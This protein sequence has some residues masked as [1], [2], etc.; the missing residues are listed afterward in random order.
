MKQSRLKRVANNVSPWMHEQVE[1]QMTN[2]KGDTTK[3]N[4]S[5]YEFVI[6]KRLLM[7]LPIVPTNERVYQLVQD[8]Y[9]GLF[10]DISPIEEAER[11]WDMWKKRTMEIL[12]NTGIL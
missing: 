2:A 12:E 7:E 3:K 1:K 10:D 4:Q 11:H 6:A 5:K 9:I 8:I